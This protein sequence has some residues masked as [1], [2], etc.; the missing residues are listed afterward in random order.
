MTRPTDQLDDFRR[1]HAP[2]WLRH[3]DHDWEYIAQGNGEV[4]LLLHGGGGTAAA[5]FAYFPALAPSFRLIA[6]SLPDSVTTSDDAI[7]GIAAIL[8]AE[9][10]AAAHVLGHSQGGYLA[11]ALSHRLPERLRTLTL[12]CTALPSPGQS[13]YVARLLR[14]LDRTPDL[15]LRPVMRLAMRRAGK[16]CG[17]ALTAE[18]SRLLLSFAPFADRARLRRWAR[19]SALLQLDYHD[20][21]QDDRRWSGRVLL[22][23][24]GRDRI[25]SAAEAAALRTRYPQATVARFEGAGHLDPIIRAAPF[26]TALQSF[27]AAR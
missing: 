15:L 16:L 11:I 20:H 21:E 26:L 27:L 1:S 4:L 10:I 2:R 25:F 12:V 24:A 3:R 9:G 22:I 7:A 13:R 19:S 6:P 14:C 5:F 23:E 18:E 8:D 17:S